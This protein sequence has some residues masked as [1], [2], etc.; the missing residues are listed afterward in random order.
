MSAKSPR[1]LLRDI[2]VIGAPVGGA[3]ALMRLTRDLPDDL[4]ASIFVVL[5]MPENRLLLAD[6]LNAPG[7]MRAADALDGEA[8]E[9]RRIYIAPAGKHLRLRG[10]KIHLS[11]NGAVKPYRPSIDVLFISA[12]ESYGSR[13]IGVL[14]V[15]AREE[16]LEGLSAIRTADGRTITHRN[17]QMPET[18]RTSNSNH[19]LSH[20]H[21]DLERIA[22]RV[23]HYAVEKSNGK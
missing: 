21:V 14:L 2:I 12:A 10:G 5:H 16:G 7:R 17:E 23:I 9:P 8:I 19:S 13:V 4:E 18:P 11:G 6:L 20:D 1:K 22:S 3:S 15:H